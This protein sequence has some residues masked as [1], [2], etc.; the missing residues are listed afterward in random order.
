MTHLVPLFVFVVRKGLF[1]RFLNQFKDIL[2]PMLLGA[3]LISVLLGKIVDAVGIE[4]VI[5]FAVSIGPIQDSLKE[6]TSKAMKGACD[7]TANPS[8]PAKERKQG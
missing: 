3:F 6:K 8:E 7:I 4:T 1:D 5:G 2:V